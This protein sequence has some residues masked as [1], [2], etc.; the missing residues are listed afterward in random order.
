MTNAEIAK[1]PQYGDFSLQQSQLSV[2]EFYDRMEEVMSP[3]PLDRHR[4]AVRSRRDRRCV[5]PG[6]TRAVDMRR[7][8]SRLH[9]K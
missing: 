2:E 6:R 9:R 5:A 3:Q 7:T 8:A 1:D 4:S